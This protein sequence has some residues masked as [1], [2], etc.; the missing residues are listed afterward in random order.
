MIARAPIL[1]EDA[2]TTNKD[3]NLQAD[4]PFALSYLTDSKK[5]WAILYAL[6]STS[7]VWQHVK[8]YSTTQNDRHV[9]R[10]LQ[11]L[12]FGGD[13]FSTMHSDIIL[14]LK[15]LC[16]SGDRK[17]YTFD[18]YC[19]AHVEQHN[20]LDNLLE[21]GVQDMGEDMKIH[22]FEEGIKDDS[23]SSVKTTILVDRSKFPTFASAMGLCSNFKRSQ[24]NDIVPQGCTILALTQGCGGG[25]QG[26]GGF[27]RGRG[28]GRGGNSRPP[29]SL[30]S[31]PLTPLLPLPLLLTLLLTL[32]PPPS[33]L[34]LQLVVDC[35]VSL[36]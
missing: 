33:F 2:N 12:F 9:W 25:G 14:T 4:G 13:K 23:F 7:T 29:P 8:K 21:Y 34:L 28:R 36:S 31:L 15:N 5:V 32:P 22:Y 16:Y 26:R 18:K 27:G 19:T 17:N 35:C 10:A 1:H 6:F 20:Q 24:K 11:E 30:S 3:I